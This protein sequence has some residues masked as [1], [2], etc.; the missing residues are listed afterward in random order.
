VWRLVSCPI[1]ASNETSSVQLWR[2]RVWR[3]PDLGRQRDTLGAAAHAETKRG[4]LD[5]ATRNFPN[6]SFG[7]PLAL[8]VDQVELGEDRASLENLLELGSI[9]GVAREAE[10]PHQPK[11][12]GD[13][14]HVCGGDLGCPPQ[15]E[16]NRCHVRAAQPG[17]V[18]ADLCSAVR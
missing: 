17:P 8:E 10:R 15:V 18:L 11:T 4:E 3:P 5:A 6:S 9:D 2:F 12:P 1:S 7:L 13:A 14:Q 16:G